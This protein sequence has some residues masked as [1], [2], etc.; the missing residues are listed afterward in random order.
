MKKRVISIITILS[1]IIFIIMFN[2][3][4]NNKKEEIIIED[5]IVKEEKQEEVKEVY[6]EPKKISFDIKGQVVNPGVYE[7]NEGSK[8]IDAVNLSG[9]FTEE[10]DTTL[11]N[12]AK[13][14]KD[15][16]VIIIYSKKEVNDAMNNNAN[17][18]TIIKKI[19]S[20]CVCPSI[21]NDACLNQQKEDSESKE[22]DSNESS[23]IIN[24][25]TASQEELM[26]LTGIGEAK[27]KA[28]IEY[29]EKNNGFKNIEDIM[30]VSGIGNSAFEKIK[31]NITK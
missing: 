18:K 26:T 16:M 1:I 30:N 15:E 21:K 19:D 7:I 24:I 2:Y 10:A 6:V 23:T 25:N 31:D 8:V 4:C 12:L 17:N 13:K 14:L 20:I 29:R 9:G 28:I 3:V 22:N 11:I 5:K 27:A